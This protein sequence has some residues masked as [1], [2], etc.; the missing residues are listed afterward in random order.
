MSA[1]VRPSP[2]IVDRLVGW[3]GEVGGDV[4]LGVVRV[5][6]AHDAVEDSDCVLVGGF[7]SF[8]DVARAHAGRLAALLVEH[9]RILI[10]LRHDV[11]GV[12]PRLHRLVAVEGGAQVCDVPVGVPGLP[13]PVGVFLRRLVRGQMARPGCAGRV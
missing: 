12:L 10:D 7:V 8:Q 1:E 6:L 11:S 2:A 13:P 9:G 3:V 4:V 5:D